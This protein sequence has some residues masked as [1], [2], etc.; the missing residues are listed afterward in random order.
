MSDLVDPGGGSPIIGA[1]DHPLAN[2]NL[3]DARIVHS[4]DRFAGIPGLGR[5]EAAYRQKLRLKSWQYM[6]AVTDELFIAFVVGTAG[7]ASNGFVYA[8]EL[9]GGAVHTKFA[10]TPLT[11][12][13]HLASSSTAGSHSFST[14]GLGITIENL[15]GGRRFAAHLEAR[16]ENGGQL[17]ADLA[18]RSRATDDHLSLC[19]PLPGGRWNYTHKF[20]AFEV[21]GRVTIDGRTI[22]LAPG[23][24][25]G[26]MDF[27]KM[28]ALRHSVWKWI[29]LSGR[30]KH[31]KL[32]GLNLV[33][34]TPDAAVSEN[35][36]WID[37]KREPLADV[38]LEQEQPT[39]AAGPWRISAENL[40]LDMRA[41]AHVE[42]RL[43]LPLVKQRLRHVVGS[44]SGRL[45]TKSG[46]I[47]DLENVVGI[48]EDYDTWW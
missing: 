37:G 10:I 46:H 32:I 47:H 33:D 23:R 17:A 42:Q 7:F 6:T 43:D 34:P 31:G 48:A 14:R 16:T 27:T 44:F 29:S 5:A 30:T 18:F 28:Y 41:V 15:D 1:W 35:A 24:S 21:S 19:V 4:L 8:A 40:D 3:E 11:V 12:G 36:L 45:L 2:P 25:Y 38:R 39:E 13:T 20:A 9:P 22:D 26:T